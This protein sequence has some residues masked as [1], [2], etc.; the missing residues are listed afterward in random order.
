MV[1]PVELVLISPTEKIK[2][3]ISGTPKKNNNP[4]SRGD[5]NLS[6]VTAFLP[7]RVKCLLPFTFLVR[8]FLICFFTL[9]PL[10]INIRFCF[11]FLTVKIYFAIGIINIEPTTVFIG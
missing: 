6:P 8:L 3:C 2:D 5:I 9:V 4:I 11:Y 7:V 1:Y 10:L